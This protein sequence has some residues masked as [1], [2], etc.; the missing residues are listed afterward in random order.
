MVEVN[1]NKENEFSGCEF[2]KEKA[3]A[4]INEVSKI[5]VGQYEFVE[6]MVTAL[7]SG[8]HVLIEG[9]PGL[10]KTLASKVMSKTIAAEFKRVQ[11]TPDL[12]PADII[13]TKVFD[14]KKTEFFLKKGPLFTN[15]FLADEINRTHP[16]TQA[17]LLEAMEEKSISID[18]ET[19]KL[20]EP[21]MV[22]ATQNP[23]E[24]EGTYPLPEAQ[25]DR[26]L[27][28]LMVDYIPQK[29]ENMLLQKYN[30]GFDSKEIEKQNINTVCSFEDLKRC[31]MEIQG[32]QVN[33]G[34][35]NYITSI[36]RATR[37]SPNLILGG[38][39]RA[40]VSMLLVAKTYAAING[41]NFVIPEDIKELALPV[42]RHRVIVKPE[43][44]IDGLTN[45]EA[46]KSILAKVEVPR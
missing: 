44:G 31:K 39:P 32:V 36:V 33:D 25:L 21:F 24:Y 28:K 8:G 23:V 20:G 45:D 14:P 42:L 3:Q 10:A 5:V 4:I 16:K 22:L 38:S 15:I 18:G 17:A 30:S 12:M 40:S 41:R 34:I 6:H 35:I 37:N 27:M 11:F 9:V 29:F 13:G 26:F 2:T 43:A 1:S 46:I 19:H 7:L